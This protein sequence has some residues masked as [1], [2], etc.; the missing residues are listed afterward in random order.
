MS[1]A[2]VA[3]FLSMS[4]LTARKKVWRR[5]NWPATWPAICAGGVVVPA[6]NW[7]KVLGEDLQPGGVVQRAGDV[8][9]RGVVAP[10][11]RGD[12]QQ[13]DGAV[14]RVVAR[15][16]QDRIA[17]EA[18]ALDPEGHVRQVV[19]GQRVAPLPQHQRRRH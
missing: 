9:R 17:G 12:R 7:A 18:R 3:G 16:V 10:P 6:K 4:W 15:H 1:M 19:A 14:V 5:K 11:L 8:E 2:W 13:Q